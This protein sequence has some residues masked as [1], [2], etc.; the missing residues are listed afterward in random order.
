MRWSLPPFLCQI[1]ELFICGPTKLCDFRIF[2]N[3]LLDY[4][5]THNVK[6]KYNIFEYDYF[7]IQI[8]FQRRGVN[9]KESRSCD[10]ES[11]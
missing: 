8:Y 3:Q 1:K 9:R 2:L 5:I 6:L 4:L 11:M 10:H 7:F